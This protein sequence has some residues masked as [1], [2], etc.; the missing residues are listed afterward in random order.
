MF[1]PQA[2]MA[3]AAP[4]LGA[5]LIRR[6]G[7]KRIYLLGLVANLV[8]DGGCSSSQFVMGTNRARTGYCC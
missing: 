8:S 6:L 7:I 5:R 2:V 1:L 4:L 3:I